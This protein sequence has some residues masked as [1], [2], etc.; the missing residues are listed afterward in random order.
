MDYLREEDNVQPTDLPTFVTLEI[1]SEFPREWMQIGYSH[2]HFGAIRLALNYYA[3]KGKPIVERIALLDSIYL[4]YQHVCIATIET[5]LNSGLVMVTLFPNFTMALADRNLLTAL[6]IVGA[7]QVPFAIVAT[8][9][10]QIVFRV[11]DHAFNFSRHGDSLLITVNTNDQPH[12]VH[13]PKQIPKKERI[14]L[15]PEK[16]G[17]GTMEIKF[18][19]SHLH[20]PKGPSIFPTQLM[21]QP[22]GNPTVGHNNEDIECCCDLCKPGPERI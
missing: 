4:E 19:H 2:I 1:R 15:L 17:N 20:R 11:Q 3:A 8:L 5:I 16:W 13:V 18:D 12:C 21:M 14:T 6:K 7:P 22:I 10:Y 9:L